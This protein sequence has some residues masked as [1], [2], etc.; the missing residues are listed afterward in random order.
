MM[1]YVGP[2]TDDA[3]YKRAQARIHSMMS[4]TPKDAA[5]AE[6]LDALT[7]ALVAYGKTRFKFWEI[8]T[9][10][11]DHLEFM[12]D[13]GMTTL[14]EL[15]PVFGGIEPLIMFMTRRRNLDRETL[16]ALVSELGIKRE[17]L[18]KPFCSPEGWQDI[19]LE[20]VDCC[21]EDPCPMGIGEWRETLLEA[22]ARM[23]AAEE[24]R[25]RMGAGR[26]VQDVGAVAAD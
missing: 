20:E 1:N 18:D 11:A 26:T 6:E 3:S 21:D 4:R 19:T 16:E 14:D 13:Q 7:D 22:R 12:L 25:E 8:E 2:I 15:I 5:E 23:E 10:G 17:D 9:D 24:R